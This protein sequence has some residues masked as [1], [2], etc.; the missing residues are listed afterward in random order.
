VFGGEPVQWA[1]LRFTPT[2]ARWVASERW[3]RDQRGR[4]EPDGHYVLEV[5]YSDPR[6]LMMDVLK[7]G[8]DVDV[9]APPSLRDLVAAE[10]ARMA[11]KLQPA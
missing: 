6:E 7:F 8:G 3:H 5:P 2:R 11:A 9:L 4:H 10:V 1:K